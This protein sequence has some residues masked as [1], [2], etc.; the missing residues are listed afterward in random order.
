MK[1]IL[2]ALLLLPL[3]LC[4]TQYIG[5]GVGTNNLSNTTSETDPKVG[6]KVHA[7]YGYQFESGFI[8]ELELHYRKNQ[9]KN[10]DFIF[11]SEKPIAGKHKREHKGN[12]YMA[13]VLYNLN[14]LALNG[15][16]PYFGAGAGF[17]ENS[18]NH[19]VVTALGKKSWKKNDN[20]FAY[21]GIIGVRFPVRLDYSVG[22]QY[23]Y[24][25]GQ[26]HAKNHSFSLH[27]LRNF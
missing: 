23:N 10:T 16:V 24:L 9:A 15:I 22:L 3:S 21:Q 19:K 26:A 25:V 4:A 17:C 27:A 13:N 11:N 14:V 8:G 5:V 2:F 7:F 6:H 1:N 12:G 20:R 18:T